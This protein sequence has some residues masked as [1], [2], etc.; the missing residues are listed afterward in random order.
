M[1]NQ[2]I[3]YKITDKY[4]KRRQKLW[5]EKLIPPA[6]TKVTLISKM[7]SSELVVSDETG[8]TFIVYP[9]DLIKIKTAE[10]DT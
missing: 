1:T 9:A 6:G 2:R 10:T 7:E 4:N 5:D 8:N 3:K